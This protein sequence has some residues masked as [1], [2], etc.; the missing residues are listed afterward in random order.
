[1]RSRERKRGFSAQRGSFLAKKCWGPTASGKTDGCNTCQCVR[2]FEGAYHPTLV[3]HATCNPKSTNKRDQLTCQKGSDCPSISPRHMKAL[4]S[5]L[6]KS[7]GPRPENVRKEYGG[8]LLDCAMCQ[9]W[10]E[11]RSGV[12]SV[13]LCKESLHGKCDQRKQTTC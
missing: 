6:C 4:T 8:L 3:A 5:N 1:M 2:S 12:C 11:C 7:V 9:P 13:R 10:L